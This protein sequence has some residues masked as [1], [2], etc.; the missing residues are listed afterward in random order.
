MRLLV[1]RPEPDASETAGRL[2]ELG[3]AVLVEPMMR[4]EFSP[5]P[6]GLAAPAAILLTSG[7]AVRALERW[8]SAAAWRRF[9]VFVIGRATAAQ[10]RNIGFTDVRTADRDAATLADLVRAEFDKAAG[11]ILYPAARDRSADMAA[12]L[13]GFMVETVEAYR[14]IAATSL[15]EAVASAIAS[16]VGGGG[17]AARSPAAGDDQGSGTAGRGKPARAHSAARVTIRAH[18][19]GRGR[20]RLYCRGRSAASLA[21][22]P[23]RRTRTSP[24][25]ANPT[26]SGGAVATGGSGRR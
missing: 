18:S 22:R 14:G 17:R 5:E 25:P 11:Q 21:R 2:R 16:A 12:M 4:I 20:I 7:N 15:D 10:A 8:P 26:A 23:W 3:H 6:A 1:T 9:P 13:A 19:R 24:R